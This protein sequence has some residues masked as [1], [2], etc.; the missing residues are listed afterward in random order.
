MK[1]PVL[2]KSMQSLFSPS[3]NPMNVGIELESDPRRVWAEQTMARNGPGQIRSA[4]RVW[5]GHDL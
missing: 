4:T 3:K 5:P 2:V 1:G